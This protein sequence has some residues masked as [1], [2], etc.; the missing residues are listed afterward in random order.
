MIY[1]F[2]SIGLFLPLI[3]ITGKFSHPPF[4]EKSCRVHRLD[5]FLDVLSSAYL[6]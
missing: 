6:G 4:S 5:R 1:S 2:Y 3:F